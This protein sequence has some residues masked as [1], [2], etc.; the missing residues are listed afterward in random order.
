MWKTGSNYERSKIEMYNKL[1]VTS[2]SL[3]HESLENEGYI[4]F[5]DSKFKENHPSI[6]WIHMFQS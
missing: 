2:I 1:A 5:N 3:L 4:Y 6:N